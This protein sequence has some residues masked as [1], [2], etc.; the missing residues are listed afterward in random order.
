MEFVFNV[1]VNVFYLLLIYNCHRAIIVVCRQTFLVFSSNNCSY[2]VK[3]S[4]YSHQI[5]VVCRQ[6]FLVFL[7][8]NFSHLISG[9]FLFSINLG[10][11]CIL[12]SFKQSFYPCFIPGNFLSFIW[13]IFYSYFI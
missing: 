1:E 5:I 11:F 12:L 6:T 13:A 10:E 8:N 7:S 2:A 3:L 4:W 9:N